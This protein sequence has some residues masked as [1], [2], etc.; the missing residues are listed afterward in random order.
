MQA[1]QWLDAED[2]QEVISKQGVYLSLGSSL[3]VKE[4]IG[5]LDDLGVWIDLDKE[6][7][8]VSRLLASL[9]SLYVAGVRFNG[10]GLFPQ[11]LRR[12]LL[13]TYPFERKTYKVSLA[14]SNDETDWVSTAGTRLLPLEKLAPLSQ[15]QRQ[16]SYAALARDLEKFATHT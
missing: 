10:T 4:Q 8:A 11:G 16:S 6:Q 12:V 3:S 5:I 9:A 15:D 14:H 1:S 7:A 2:C 13:P